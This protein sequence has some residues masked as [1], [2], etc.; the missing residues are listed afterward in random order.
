M[1]HSSITLDHVPA[2]SAL[3]DSDYQL[4]FSELMQIVQLADKPLSLATIRFILESVELNKEEV[5]SL[6]AFD[7][8]NY[9]RKRLFRNDHSEIL[10]LSWL[11][12]QRSKIHDHLDT[13]CG[14][15]VLHGEAT[16]TRFETAASGHIYATKSA[17][18]G[19]GNVTVSKDNDIHQISNLQADDKPLMTLHIYSPPLHKFHLYDLE[20]GS[21]E[22]LN[23]EQDSWF[24]EI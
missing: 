19:K 15:K 14:V 4:S 12:G 1:D 23:L 20:D 21:P 7:Q 17:L 13:A 8:D 18:F 3:L 10:I 9:C 11:N 24:Y 2:L 22:L 6:A 5:E 16:E